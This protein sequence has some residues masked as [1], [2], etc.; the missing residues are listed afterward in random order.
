MLSYR[1]LQLA[2][3]GLYRVT[4]EAVNGVAGRD[5]G[6]DRTLRVLMYHKVNDLSPNPITVPTVVFA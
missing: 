6:A 5:D 1:A 3:N 4:G 2:K